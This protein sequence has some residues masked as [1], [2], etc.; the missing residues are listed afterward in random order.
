MHIRTA[1]PII[2][3]ANL[4]FSV[5]EAW[6]DVGGLAAL[7]QNMPLSYF[8]HKHRLMLLNRSSSFQ[9]INWHIPATLH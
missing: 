5:E 2:F 8:T 9:T 1:A 6:V 3:Y 4:H 7:Q